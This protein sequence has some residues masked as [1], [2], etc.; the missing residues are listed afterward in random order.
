LISV[1]IPAYHVEV[2]PLIVF[3]QEQA[4]SSRVI[5]EIIVWDDASNIDFSPLKEISEVSFFRSPINKGR[6]ATRTLLAGKAK[7]P[8]L[9]FL[10]ADVFPTSDIFLLSYSRYAAG[11]TIVVG[12][13][14]YERKRP[15]DP[16]FFRWYY[17]KAREELSA[18]KRGKNPYNHF[19]TGNFLIPKA[20]FLRFP[21]D[22]VPSAYGHED[23]LL[24]YLFQKTGIPICHIDNPVFHLGLEENEVFLNKSKEAVASLWHLRNLG[25]PLPVRLN[26]AFNLLAQ[27][28]LMKLAA[29]F[30]PLL[31]TPMI[32]KVFFSGSY[33]SLLLFDLYKLTYLCRLALG[34]GK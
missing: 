27:S 5:I 34:K 25:Y 10:D 12:G 2:A 23:T 1:L 7:Y 18:G 15:A 9:L 19:M 13:I 24:G 31:D 22:D 32:K 33:G 17:G 6:A 21:L 30:Y 14:K 16:L 26:R 11:D 8:C 28:N 4:V 29:V 3:L 20:I